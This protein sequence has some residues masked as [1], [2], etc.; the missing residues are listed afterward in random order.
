MHLLYHYASPNTRPYF[1]KFG[2]YN[3]VQRAQPNSMTN[4]FFNF[5]STLI[6][7]AIALTVLLTAVPA[8]ATQVARC[9]FFDD[10]INRDVVEFYEEKI[11]G[12]PF[13]SKMSQKQID[14]LKS[15]YGVDQNRLW[16][17]LILEDLGARVDNHK[18]LAELTK[19]KDNQLFSHGKALVESYIATLTDEQKED[20]KAGFKEALGG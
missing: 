7:V 2:V 1:V 4:T 15:T 5:R 12:E 20:L 16:L 18:D 10:M 13:V 3:F 9:A 14:L 6:I 19:M 8:P 11:A 17:L